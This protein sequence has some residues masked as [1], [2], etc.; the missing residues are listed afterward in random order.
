MKTQD[1]SVTENEQAEE[2]KMFGIVI[3]ILLAVGFIAL[4]AAAT[5]NKKSMTQNQQNQS[6]SSENDVIQDDID[7]YLIYKTMQNDDEKK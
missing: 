6:K 7:M 1:A 3:G 5:G 4:V 2:R